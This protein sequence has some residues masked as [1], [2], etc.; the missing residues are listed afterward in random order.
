[1]SQS[2]QS[3]VYNINF[4]STVYDFQ[5]LSSFHIWCK[6]CHTRIAYDCCLLSV[7]G[8]SL[9][10]LFVLGLLVVDTETFVAQTDCAVQADGVV[11]SFVA[12]L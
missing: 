5:D 3:F 1:M 11:L 12:V 2:F 9:L 6:P 4:Q 8:E 10:H 7:P